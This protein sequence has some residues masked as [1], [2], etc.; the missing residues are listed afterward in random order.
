MQVSGALTGKACKKESGQWGDSDCYC[1]KRRGH[2][3][4]HSCSVCNQEWNAS[5]HLVPIC[6]CDECWEANG[7]PSLPDRPNP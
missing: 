6:Y 3:G 5:G 1:D 4:N 7:I 2:E